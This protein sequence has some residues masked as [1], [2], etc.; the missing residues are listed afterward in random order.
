M[1]DVTARVFRLGA[2]V[3]LLV[4]AVALAVW[5]MPIDRYE[6][7][8]PLQVDGR[9]GSVTA[10]ETDLRV[11]AEARLQ[12][13][14]PREL[15]LSPMTS[16]TV[17]ELHV[18]PGA[19]IDCG[20]V[21]MSVDAA[22]LLAFC[23]LRPL[24]REIDETTVGQDVDEFM[25]F[26][27]EL[28]FPP[29]VDAAAPSRQERRSRL[30]QFEALVGL[31]VDGRISPGDVYWLREPVEVSSIAVEVGDVLSGGELFASTDAVLA[32]ASVS[33]FE[34]AGAAWE[35]HLDQSQVRVAIAGDGSI[36]DLEGL[37]TELLR[38]GLLV[39]GLPESATGSIRLAS[40]ITVLAIPAAAVV[41][42]NGPCV[43]EVSEAED[44]PGGQRI[45]PV[46]IDIVSSSVG[47]VLVEAEMEPGAHVDLAPPGTC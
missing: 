36:S 38:R 16:G 26:T 8:E 15:V 13:G 35:F 40:P 44:A 20:G 14:L 28:G 18:E 29:F 23:G 7:S 30:R 11:A 34:A 24:W 19:R 32:A 22:D 42:A 1:G 25:A 10:Q 37:Q 17:T 6:P 31:P 33:Q 27:T 3:V 4:G 39:E 12:W 5:V 45:G 43:F 41:T 2:L 21:L 9:V 46:P 47:G